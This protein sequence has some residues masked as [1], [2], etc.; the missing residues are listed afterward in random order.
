MCSNISLPPSRLKVNNINTW[1][2]I[3]ILAY[4]F[5]LWNLQ[6]H[7]INLPGMEVTYL[8]GNLFSIRLITTPIWNSAIPTHLVSYSYCVIIVEQ[9]ILYWER[10]CAR[11]AEFSALIKERYNDIVHMRDNNNK[12]YIKKVVFD[13]QRVTRVTRLGVHHHILEI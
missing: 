2:Q 13:R 11:I 4:F 6:K 8:D 12:K 1:I 7:P 3:K 5:L 10:G 9:G